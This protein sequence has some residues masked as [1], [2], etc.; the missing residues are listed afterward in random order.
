MASPNPVPQAPT[1][2]SAPAR[3]GFTLLELLVVIGIIAL[4]VSI[5]FVVGLRVSGTGKARATEQ[6]LKSVDAILSEYQHADAGERRVHGWYWDRTASRL[7]PAVDGRFDGRSVN[8]STAQFD[9]LGDPAQPSLGLMLLEMG[10]SAGAVDAMLKGIDPKFI[11]R[12]PV[13]AYAWR[14]NAQGKVVGVP[15]PAPIELVEILDG[16]GNPI[17]CVLPGFGGGYGDYYDNG[18]PGNMT[19]R[20]KLTITVPSQHS[21]TPQ[22]P[23]TA[24]FTR[25]YRPFV[26]GSPA[27]ANPVGDADEGSAAGRRPYVYSAGADGDPGTRADNI[28]KDKPIFPRETADQEAQ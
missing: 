23:E 22:S 6:V 9:R 11:V 18:P 3:A 20:E 4:L 8:P 12:R 21:N 10:G 17:R 24:L 2:H 15:G 25:S 16:W 28:Y 1:F 5:T 19:T 7:Y 27:A 13:V 26:P 14:T